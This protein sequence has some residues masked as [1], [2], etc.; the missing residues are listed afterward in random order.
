MYSPKRRVSATVGARVVGPAV[1]RAGARVEP[2][3]Q[4]AAT[5]ANAGE[6]I[7]D[8][9]MRFMPDL[10]ARYPG[11]TFEFEG[12]AQETAVT[13]A[14]LQRNFLLGLAAVFLLLCFQ[15]RSYLESTK[16]P[17]AIRRRIPIGL[18]PTGG[19]SVEPGMRS[20]PKRAMRTSQVNAETPA[21]RKAPH[22]SWYSP[23]ALAKWW[24]AL[25]R[26]RPQ[27]WTHKDTSPSSAPSTFTELGTATRQRWH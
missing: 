16:N 9:R 6:L 24:G 3:R 18:I 27:H 10:L 22:T 26:N 4:W 25:F 17:V 13:G 5:I 14:S 1:G 12:Q 20:R 2:A 19:V 7:A 21:S 15:F 8:T 23:I 11:L